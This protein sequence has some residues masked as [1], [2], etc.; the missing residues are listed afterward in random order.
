[1]I[2]LLA[3]IA[4]S[5]SGYLLYLHEVKSHVVT[6]RKW[7]AAEADKEWTD[8]LIR[9]C[10]AIAGYPGT[11]PKAEAQLMYEMLTHLEKRGEQ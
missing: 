2:M 3:Y 11:E 1:M 5:L 4:V 6:Y 9:L 8:E 10:E 7:K